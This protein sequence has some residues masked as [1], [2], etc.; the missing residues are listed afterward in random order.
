MALPSRIRGQECTILVVRAGV[1]EDSIT[2]VMNFNFE[3]QGETKTQGYLGEKNNRTD[4]IF[5]QGKFDFE[6]HLTTQQWLTF[7]KAIQDRQ[8]R[9]TPDV[10]FNIS[11]VLEFANGETPTVFFNDCKFGAI[12]N[13]IASRGD[14]VKVKFDGMV[15]DI[16]FTTS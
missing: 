14:Y 2:S 15:D 4:D 12:P 1:L 13:N 8:K 6:A 9:V 16:S 5:N 7:I 11:V 3:Y 10:Q